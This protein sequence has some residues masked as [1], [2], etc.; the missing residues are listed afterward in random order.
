LDAACAWD[1]CNGGKAGRGSENR[2]PSV[3]AVESLT[4]VSAMQ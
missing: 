3:I 4:E 2:R 1:E